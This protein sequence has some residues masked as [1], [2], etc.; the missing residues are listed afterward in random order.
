MA[1]WALIIAVAS[2]IFAACAALIADTAQ[3][4]QREHNKLSV[5]PHLT[6]GTNLTPGEGPFVSIKSDGLGPARLTGFRVWF[7]GKPAEEG[8]SSNSQ[9][10]Y[11]ELK[12]VMPYFNWLTLQ[13][14]T[15]ILVG[16][17]IKLIEYIPPNMVTEESRGEIP[18]F[19]NCLKKLKFEIKYESFYEEAQE[20]EEWEGTNKADLPI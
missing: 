4:E 5:V 1:F 11:Q 9:Y 3:K 20:T 7:D 19:I 14:G 8:N 2:A 16:E 13:P 15:A 6:Y 17:E 12:K 10:V 18:T